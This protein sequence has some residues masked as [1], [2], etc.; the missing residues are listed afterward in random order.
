MESHASPETVT[1]VTGRSRRLG[2]QGVGPLHLLATW[3]KAKS[4][5]EN[6]KQTNKQTNKQTKRK[7]KTKWR[8]G[9]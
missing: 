5:K 4:N 8:I 7:H 2:C 1:L 9:R 6:P 3:S